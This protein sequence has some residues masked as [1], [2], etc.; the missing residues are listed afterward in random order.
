MK[1]IGILITLGM[2]ALFLS[3]CGE[4]EKEEI[5]SLH[6]SFHDLTEDIEGKMEESEEIFMQY[7]NGTV[8]ESEF[9]DM[10]DDLTGYISDKKSEIDKINKPKKDKAVEYYDISKKALLGAYDMIELIVDIPDLT[11]EAAIIEYGETIE[12]KTEEVEGDMKAV[13]EFQNDLKEEDDDY[14]ELF[15]DED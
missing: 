8:D 3:A 2:V 4:S 5:T 14:K 9:E 15:E 10:K 6:N 7:L 11:D 13:E 1:K 12:G